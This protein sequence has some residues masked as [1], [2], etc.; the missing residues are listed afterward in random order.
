MRKRI[1]RHPALMKRTGIMMKEL[2]SPSLPKAA[3]QSAGI[4]A[5]IAVLS[6]LSY[7]AGMLIGMIA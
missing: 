5:A 6:A 1:R 7:G 4:I 2:S 3:M